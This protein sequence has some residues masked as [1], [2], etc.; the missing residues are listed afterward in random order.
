MNSA[1]TSLGVGAVAVGVLLAA[2]AA[3]NADPILDQQAPFTN[4]IY[5]SGTSL[6]W[7]QEIEVG[8]AGPLAG[9]ELYAYTPGSAVLYINAGAPWQA[10][11]ND[12]EMTVSPSGIGWFFIDTSAAN[13]NFDVG[14]H[15]VI[16]IQGTAGGLKM[17]G[18]S[19]GGYP[20][21][22]LYLGGSAYG[23]PNQHDFGFRTYVIPAPGSIVLL[24]L[25]TPAVLRRRR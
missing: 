22:A 11:D 15:F 18:S 1:K 24:S 3:V 6:N 2:S 21:G 12:F 7:Q 5:Y 16:G 10:D 14:D 25:L 4:A 19:P 17:G 13:I 20:E 9:V 8:L 23:S